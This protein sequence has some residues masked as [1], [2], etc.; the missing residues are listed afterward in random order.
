MKNFNFFLLNVS[1]CY[2]ASQIKM[3]HRDT[4]PK[5]TPKRN[6]VKHFISPPS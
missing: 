3:Y 2:I 5:S 4:T 1:C 6:V